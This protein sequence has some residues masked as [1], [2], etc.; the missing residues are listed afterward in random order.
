MEGY[1]EIVTPESAAIESDIL[2]WTD[3]DEN[4]IHT[5]ILLTP[6]TLPNSDRLDYATLLR[7]K[8]G[9]LPEADMSLESLAAGIEGYGENYCVYRRR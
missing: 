9:N 1:Y 4:P 8:N 6:V 3:A 7:S 2:V 5:L